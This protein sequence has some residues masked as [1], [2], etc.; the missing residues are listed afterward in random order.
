MKQVAAPVSSHTTILIEEVVR[1]S[2]AD[3]F[4]FIGVDKNGVSDIPNCR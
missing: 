2:T 4:I 1:G 3:D